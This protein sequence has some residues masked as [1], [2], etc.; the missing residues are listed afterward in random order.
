MQLGMEDGLT[1][2]LPWVVDWQLISF[3]PKFHL[4][5][6]LNFSKVFYSVSSK[7]STWDT[8]WYRRWYGLKLLC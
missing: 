7:E 2:L 8:E 1:E 6:V 5:I 3:I 4:V